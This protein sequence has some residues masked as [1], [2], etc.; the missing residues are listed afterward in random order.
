MKISNN[1]LTL[2]LVLR[3]IEE[4][5]KSLES[6]TSKGFLNSQDLNLFPVL[7]E[8]IPS[9]VLEGEMSRKEYING[10]KSMEGYK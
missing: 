4:I 7:S 1:S 8:I 10:E 5:I 9:F 3:A 2:K 6:S